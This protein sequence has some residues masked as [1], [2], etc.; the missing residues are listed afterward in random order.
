MHF[1]IS[2]GHQM[3]CIQLPKPHSFPKHYIIMSTVHNYWTI[4]VER[5]E[6]RLFPPTQQVTC[7]SGCGHKLLSQ[8]FPTIWS[9]NPKPWPHYIFRISD[10]LFSSFN[11]CFGIFLCF[12]FL[13]SVVLLSESLDVFKELV[14]VDG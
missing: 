2:S 1:K 3:L 10:L 14:A 11:K 6:R 5:N 7:S 12:V 9:N 13:T 4:E 8:G